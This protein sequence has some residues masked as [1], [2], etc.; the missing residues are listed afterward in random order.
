MYRRSSSDDAG[1]TLVEV[2]VAMLVFA[3]VLTGFLYTV[4]ASIV[5]TRD[6]RARV[7]A[8]NLASE[9]ID[10]ARSKES[11]FDVVSDV[12]T[13]TLNGDTFRVEIDTEWVTAT[14]ATASCDA[15]A[16]SSAALAYKHVTVTV[17]WEGMRGARPVVTDTALTPATKINDPSLGTV[18]VGVVD[19]AG[20]GVPGASV[21]LSPAGVPAVTTDADG[22]AYL[23][24]VPLGTYTVSVSKSGYISD[25]QIVTPSAEIPVTAGGSSRVSFAYD[26]AN[27]FTTTYA[28]GVPGT[29]R[30]PTNLTT[31]YISTYGN[32][33][34]SASTN[35]N[36][37]SVQLYPYSSG[38]SV[39]AGA[40]A[41][42]PGNPATSCLAPDPGSWLDTPGLV[43]VR[44]A[45]AAGAPGAPVVATAGM[46]AVA[47][48]GI[49]GG[50]N[51]LRAVYVGGGAGD[52]GC[53]AGMSYSF[54]N[55]IVGNAASI[56]LPY[57]TWQLYRGDA[58]AQNTLISG[59]I[60]VLTP[61]LVSGAT[62]TLDPRVAG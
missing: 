1:F 41:E 25:Q 4:T 44:P 24:K 42:T 37:K 5:T 17:T 49:S 22:C 28:A 26:V 18:L 45:P 3:V 60:T 11:V 54:G 10:L 34:T 62:V 59:G 36:P 20:E 38:Y 19:S 14:G 13:V 32:F 27:T 61:G 53:Q 30:L 55:I 40:F 33:Q 8:A 31:T 21:S 9:Q 46:G 47:L 56:A 50:G 51:Y 43:G 15:G 6:T 7:V 2:I 39:V 12:D 48:S 57:G 52:P 16:A 29:F 23:L 58:T 35:A